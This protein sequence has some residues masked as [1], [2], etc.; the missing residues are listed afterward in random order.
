[1][2]DIARMMEAGQRQADHARAL[3]DGPMQEVRG[4][5]ALAHSFVD[6]SAVVLPSG[7]RTWPAMLGASS[8]PFEKAVRS[9]ALVDERVREALMRR[10]AER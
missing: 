2:R 7:Q 3:F 1:R 8:D 10:A 4:E 5:I 9:G 6:M